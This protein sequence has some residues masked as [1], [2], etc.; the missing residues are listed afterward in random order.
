MTTP[1]VPPG[2]QLVVELYVRD[3]KKSCEFYLKLGFEMVRDDGNFLVLKWEDAL[4]FLEEVEDALPPPAYPVGNI[5]IMVPDVDHYWELSRQL[6]AR[7]IRPIE[8]RYYGLRDFT[9]AGPDGL[10][11]RFGT[12]ISDHP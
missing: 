5:R 10:A 11:I 6:G 12:R 1:H 7:V 9:V 3:I 4:L 8:D 2:E